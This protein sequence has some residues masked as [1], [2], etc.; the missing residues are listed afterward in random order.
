MDCEDKLNI[1]QILTFVQLFAILCLIILACLASYK[2]RREISP[3]V[4]PHNIIER[5]DNVPPRIIIERIDN[6]PDHNAPPLNI[7]IPNASVQ[8]ILNHH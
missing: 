3:N 4:S 8:N 5:I 6:A 2:K 1:F 7:F